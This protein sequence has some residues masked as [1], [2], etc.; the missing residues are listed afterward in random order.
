MTRHPTRHHVLHKQHG[1]RD[2]ELRNINE[3]IKW[4]QKELRDAQLLAARNRQK[5][6]EKQMRALQ[7]ATGAL[8]KPEAHAHVEAKHETH[9]WGKSQGFPKQPECDQVTTVTPRGRDRRLLGESS[10]RRRHTMYSRRG[11][12]SAGVSRS[13]EHRRHAPNRKE[14]EARRFNG[15]DTSSSLS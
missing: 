3:E 5:Q 14:V 10:N 1:E 12:P 15:K 9:E 11:S 13:P 8:C 2:S 6:L 7:E 4:L